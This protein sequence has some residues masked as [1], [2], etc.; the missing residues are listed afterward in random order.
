MIYIYFML[1]L[2]GLLLAFVFCLCLVY[3]GAGVVTVSMTQKTVLDDVLKQ[4][5]QRDFE[6]LQGRINWIELRDNLKQGLK[7]QKQA[8]ESLGFGNLQ[9]GPRLE[10]IDAVVDY[11]VQ[12]A[13]LRV[14]MGLKDRHFKTTEPDAFVHDTGLVS[15]WAWKATFGLPVKSVDREDILSKQ[16]KKLV[17]RARSSLTVSLI[18]TLDGFKW[19]V[20][21]MNVPLFLVPDRAYNRPLNEIYTFPVQ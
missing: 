21:D 1:R 2:T 18:F 14:L 8:M 7:D 12:P 15:A 16:Q 19:R 20:T 9:G 3:L 10:D 6:S 13:N 11:Y 5:G 4:A 17:S